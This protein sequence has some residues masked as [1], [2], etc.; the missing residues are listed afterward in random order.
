MV[1]SKL[2]IQEMLLQ[3]L[4]KQI[5][6]SLTIASAD[7]SHSYA[8]TLELTTNTSFDNK[9]DANDRPYRRSPNKKAPK[10]TSVIDGKDYIV[11]GSNSAEKVRVTDLNEIY[12]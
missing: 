8:H 4:A 5:I 11:S 3:F 2:A 12:E 10:I 1:C 6:P 9:K 7:G